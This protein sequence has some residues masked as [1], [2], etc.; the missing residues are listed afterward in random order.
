MQH[1]RDFSRFLLASCAAGPRLGRAQVS[2][3]NLTQHGKQFLAFP[4]R[5]ALGLQKQPNTA[6]YAVFGASGPQK[7]S[8]TTP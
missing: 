2:K 6:P 3:S 5:S 1:A 7:Q 4:A 8:T